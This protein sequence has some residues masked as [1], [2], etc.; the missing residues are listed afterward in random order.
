MCSKEGQDEGWLL[1]LQIDKVFWSRYSRLVVTQQKYP[2]SECRS[3]SRR[4]RTFL[5]ET[6]DDE[7]IWHRDADD[8]IVK[9]LQAYG[10]FLQ[11]DGQLPQKLI[12]GQSYSIPR[13]S[14]HRVLKKK[15]C[16]NL[17]VEIISTDF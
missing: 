10:W 1:G 4:I 6:D 2:F 7:L 11:M 17:V 14:W 3:D 12:F 9:V 5:A 8:R 16:Q 15:G 13:N